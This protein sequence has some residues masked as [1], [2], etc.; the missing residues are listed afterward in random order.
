MNL[1][2]L[3]TEIRS[4]KPFNLENFWTKFEQSQSKIRKTIQQ[5]IADFK[6]NNNLT[7]FADNKIELPSNNSL[8]TVSEKLQDYFQ[9]ADNSWFNEN[10]ESL[11]LQVK[12]FQHSGLCSCCSC[13]GNQINGAQKA[14]QEGSPFETFAFF[15]EAGRK[16]SQPGGRGNPVN[17]TYSFTNLLDGS[18]NGISVTEAKAAIEEAFR[19]WSEVAP[20][21]FT[22]VP[23][24]PRESQI[25]IGQDYIDG[26][27]NTLGFAYFPG[28][29][30]GGDI[31]FD[32]GE[33]WTN[34]LF[35]ETA[36]HE[37]GHSLGLGHESRTNAI[38]NPSVKNRFNGLGTG[39]LLPDDIN[40]IRSVY[41]SGLGSVTPFGSNP[42]NPEPIPGPQATELKWEAQ[43]LNDEAAIK[44]G[45][46]FDLSGGLTT[47]VN[48]Q[49]ITDGGSFIPYA[50]Q[51]YVSFDSGKTGNH[52]G[53]LSLGFNNSKNDPDDL[54]KLSLDFNKPVTGLTFKLLDVD[55][56]NRKTFDDGVEI[57]TDGINI[58]NLPGVEI[59]TGQN[60][61]PDNEMYMN[62]F[63]GRGN[64]NDSSEAG[65]ITLNLGNTKVSVLEI[66]YFSTDDAISNP[67]GQ[68]I[69]ISDLSFQV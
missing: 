66:E 67:G 20:L 47:T 34:N 6:E 57:Y 51:D 26:R 15:T 3:Q 59:I 69:G 54:I 22:E 39:F 13:G 53:Y 2:N 50:G 7:E 32:N 28:Q 33:R 1:E 19:L 44:S 48:W 43:G 11:S 35:L 9:T 65:N 4:L 42:P 36:V 14:I 31:T 45:T 60:V 61:I 5:Q 41:G 21:N 12:H 40:G 25:R 18:L 30:V 37:I 23:D 62:G 10:L 64:A 55:Q 17:I 63:E 29:G 68:K 27:G 49:V 16:W 38:M 58:K 8:N 46:V 24:D 56:S 52:T